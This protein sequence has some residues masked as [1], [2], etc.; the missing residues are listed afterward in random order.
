M[1]T[2]LADG[3][4]D[5]EQT[6]S[7]AHLW[8]GR[9]GTADGLLGGPGTETPRGGGGGVRGR[10]RGGD[11]AGAGGGS[12]DRRG[13][14]RFGDGMSGGG[15]FGAGSGRSTPAVV[16]PPPPPP[17]RESRRG[18]DSDGASPDRGDGGRDGSRRRD[19]D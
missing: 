7:M 5:L 2:Q 4:I 14:S 6:A 13:G 12:D 16:S 19:K 11:D 8:A 3:E 1:L 18:A 17:P 15:I 9:G 10:G